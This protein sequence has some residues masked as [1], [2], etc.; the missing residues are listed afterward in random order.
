MVEAA[1]D[2]AIGRGATLGLAY[3]EQL[4]EGQSGPRLQG[5]TG[6][7]ILIVARKERLAVHKDW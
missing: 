2:V 5:S 6:C 4:A 1:P 7:Q 3:N